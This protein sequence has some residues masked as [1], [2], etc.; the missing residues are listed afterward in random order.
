[1]NKKILILEGSPR[2]GGKCIQKDDMA[3]I[4]EKILKAN[5]VVLASPVYFYSWT[6]QI[7]AVIDRTFAI[8]PTLTNTKFYLLS[9]GAAPE[10]K[11]MENMTKSFELY[12]SCFRAR[13]VENAS[14]LYRLGTNA[15]GEVRNTE[16]MIAAYKLGKTV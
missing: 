10:L 4:Y 8:E 5:V 13:G 7:K 14:V 11:Y 12:L 3:E 16:A 9:A 15:P 2:K 1:M 6:A